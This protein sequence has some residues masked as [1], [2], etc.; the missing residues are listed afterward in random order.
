MRLPSDG[1]GT[2]QSD[3]ISEDERNH[4]LRNRHPIRY[5]IAITSRVTLELEVCLHADK[6]SVLIV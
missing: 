5:R 6:N 1:N 3:D 4:L 2:A